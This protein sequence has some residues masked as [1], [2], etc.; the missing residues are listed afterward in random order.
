MQVDDIH[1]F[2]TDLLNV[3]YDRDHFKLA[4]GQL[5]MART[6]IGRVSQGKLFCPPGAAV[7][8]HACLAAR[9]QLSALPES[10]CESVLIKS[11]GQSSCSGMQLLLLHVIMLQ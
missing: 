8:R 1:P 2:Y 10:I 3:L 5:H 4:L 11:K 7:A 9:E 6:L